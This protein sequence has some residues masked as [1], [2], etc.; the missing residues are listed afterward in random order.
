MQ[1]GI[2]LITTCYIGNKRHFKKRVSRRI[3]MK[4]SSIENRIPEAELPVY[5]QLSSMP[6]EYK[7]L[8][9]QLI[10]QMNKDNI[11]IY[12]GD[13]NK[14]HFL[15]EKKL[16]LHNKLYPFKRNEYSLFI[17]QTAPHLLRILKRESESNNRKR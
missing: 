2:F 16:I 3:G 5:K 4:L 8:L 1:L 12:R 15:L 10:K 13:F 9:W 11:A 17:L 6:R 14:L 7:L